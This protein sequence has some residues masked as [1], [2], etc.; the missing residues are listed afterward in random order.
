MTDTPSDDGQSVPFAATLAAIR[1]GAVL[2]EATAGLKEVVQAAVE[3]G[4]KAR[5]TLV[6]TVEP[7]K[8]NADAFNVSGEVKTTVPSIPAATVFFADGGNLVREDPRQ[9]PLVDLR[10]LN[11]G[12]RDN[13]REVNAR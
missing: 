10:E 9:A 1:R 7:V 12:N 13:V 11:P 5:L 2:D 4:K 8:G 6:I 3:T